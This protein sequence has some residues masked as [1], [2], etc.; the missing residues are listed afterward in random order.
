MTA[1]YLFF[2]MFQPHKKASP[3]SGHT[4]HAEK[5]EELRKKVP[6][7]F[8]LEPTLLRKAGTLFFSNRI[9]FF[10][11]WPQPSCLTT[12][13]EDSSFLQT[14]KTSLTHLYISDLFVFLQP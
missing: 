2:F 4:P 3:A 13:I 14:T 10:H 11:A 5:A 7:F 12:W 9:Y 1:N 8:S 6:A